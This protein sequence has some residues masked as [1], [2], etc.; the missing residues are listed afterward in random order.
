MGGGA[1]HRAAP[2]AAG[3]HDAPG[4]AERQETVPR[5]DAVPARFDR[6][7][8][9][10]RYESPVPGLHPSAVH[11]RPAE[12]GPSMGARSPLLKAFG[13]DF[14]WSLL[15]ASPDAMV[16][17]AG[18]G[19]V[20][21]VNDHAGDLFGFELDDL[22]GR[23][24]R[25]SAALGLQSVHR[26]HRTRYR[27]E[28]TVRSMGAGLDLWARRSDGSEF[29]VEISLSPLR[30][31]DDIFAI[32]AVRDISRAGR[33]RGPAASCPAHPGRDR[34]RRV[35]LR[36]RPRC[37]SGS[38]TKAPMRLVGYERADLLI[39]VAA[40]PEPLYDRRSSTSAWCARCWRTGLVGGA[41]VDPVAE[42]RTRGA[43]GED[44]PIGAHRT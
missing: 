37:G 15:D 7:Y 26:A 23:V 17:V 20:V 43:G 31:G 11:S 27:A 10:G 36:R 9:A 42:G 21:F 22:L 8:A 29:P 28:P 19:E 13:D 14:S 16:I 41:P 1:A 33:G 12:E 5:Y 24:G 2:S 34:R 18:T 3:T 25:G 6:V 35:H 30:L 44:V 38:S 4:P 32:A 40:A 39:D